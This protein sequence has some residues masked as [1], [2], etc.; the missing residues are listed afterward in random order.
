[1]EVYISSTRQCA[2]VVT[3]SWDPQI[4]VMVFDKQEDA[5]EFIKEDVSREH[6]LDTQENGFDSEYVIFEDENRAILTVHGRDEDH[7]TEWRIGD[8]FE[9][10]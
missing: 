4:S 5:W 8:V 2:V 10:S 7:V 9:R 6:M 1:M 3:F